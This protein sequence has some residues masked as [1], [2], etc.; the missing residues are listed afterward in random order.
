MLG[1][2]RH[3]LTNEAG[4]TLVEGLVA[5]LLLLIGM[6]GSIGIFESS[7]HESA[8]GERQQIAAE[9]AQ[10]ELER[11]RELPYNELAINNAEGWSPSGAAGDP[12]ER[13]SGTYPEYQFAWNEAEGAEEMVMSETPNRGISPYTPASSGATG[14]GGPGMTIY[15]FVSW[16]DEECVLAD[17]STLTAGLEGSLDALVGITPSLMEALL[18]PGG[19][20]D[21]VIALLP[22]VGILNS[23]KTSLNGVKAR[24]NQAITALSGGLTGLQDEIDRIATLEIDPC[25]M[26][27]EPLNALQ[28]SFLFEGEVAEALEALDAALEYYEDH[29]CLLNILGIPI[30]L[31][32][33]QVAYNE[34]LA[35][36]AE[37]NLE[38]NVSEIANDLDELIASLGEIEPFDTTHNTKRVTVAV[39]LD[40]RA[41]AGPSK[42]VWASTIVSDPDSSLFTGP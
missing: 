31:G 20:L 15:R 38:I 3:R 26:N 27:L 13:I 9:R 32:Q 41:S 33:A 28:N 40:E 12:I 10:A 19:I 39:V 18:L 25:D 7:G 2:A 22:A 1:R 36:I 35:A 14:G 24:L 11:I 37:V 30:C 42:P 6:L 4:F 23:L 21:D 17:L 29:P 5:G 8:T 16:R 34:L